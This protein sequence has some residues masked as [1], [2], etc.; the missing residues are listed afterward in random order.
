MIPEDT[1]N[2]IRDRVDLVA[3]IGAVVPLKRAGATWKGCC[4]F[5]EE[6]TPS[7]SVRPLQGKYRCFGCGEGGDAFRF[8]MKTR[9]VSF[10]EAVRLVAADVGVSVP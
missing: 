6:R 1:L 7:F 5:H 2:A 3:I 8:V 10:P 4:P 9:G